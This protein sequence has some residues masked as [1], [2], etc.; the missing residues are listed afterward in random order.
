MKEA[1]EK[2]TRVVLH[3]GEQFGTSVKQSIDIKDGAKIDWH[4][5]GVKI[6]WKK[7]T[8]VCGAANIRQVQCEYE[9][10]D[11]PLT[12]AKIDDNLV[13]RSPGR[14]ARVEVPTL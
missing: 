11:A 6:T 2:I 3:V 13:R 4:E 1:T 9:G 5:L 14:P 7:V 8:I 10:G 12:I